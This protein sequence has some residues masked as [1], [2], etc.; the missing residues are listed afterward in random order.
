MHYKYEAK[1]AGKN[2]I[3][4]LSVSRTKGTHFEYYNKYK[5]NKKRSHNAAVARRPPVSKQHLHGNQVKN[6]TLNTA[7]YTNIH[8]TSS[9]YFTIEYFV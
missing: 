9:L 7:V 3:G 8:S 5:E 2:D 4:T 6:T 1:K